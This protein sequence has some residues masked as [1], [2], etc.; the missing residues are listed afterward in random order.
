M[1]LSRALRLALSRKSFSSM[2]SHFLP[3]RM[4]TLMLI[5]W[6]TKRR[7]PTMAV[8][9]D[10]LAWIILMDLQVGW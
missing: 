4:C 1:V 8:G 7:I 5:L 10:G 6:T 3:S 2:A 9:S